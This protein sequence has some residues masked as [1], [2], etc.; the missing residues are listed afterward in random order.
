M[1]PALMLMQRFVFTAVQAAYE[2]ASELTST[3]ITFTAV[4][5]AYEAS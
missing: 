5:A 2:L 3:A 1:H 4:Q